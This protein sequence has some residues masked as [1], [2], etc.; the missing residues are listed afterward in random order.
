MWLLRVRRARA[1]SSRTKPSR[2][3]A[4]WSPCSAQVRSLSIWASSAVASSSW[5]CSFFWRLLAVARSSATPGTATPRTSATMI[6]PAAM[7]RD[8]DNLAS[9]GG[10]RSRNPRGGPEGGKPERWQGTIAQPR[11]RAKTQP[12]HPVDKKRPPRGCGGRLIV[13]RPA[14][15]ADV[16]G[17]AGGG[18]PGAAGGGRW[19]GGTTGGV[20]RLLPVGGSLQPHPPPSSRSG[21]DQACPGFLHQIF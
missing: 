19:W 7:T 6:R 8:L 15:D 18:W 1:R 9:V 11:R 20:F 2:L 3:L 17:R 10:H 16:R 12:V 5:A 4:A 21:R 14:V 13:R